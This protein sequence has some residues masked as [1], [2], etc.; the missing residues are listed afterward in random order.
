[1]STSGTIALTNGIRICAPAAPRRAGRVDGEDVL[2]MVEHVG[3]GS[4]D[5]AVHRAH[6]EADEIAVAELVGVVQ[7]A[8][9][10]RIDQQPGAAEL[11]RGGPCR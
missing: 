10:G 8:E 11:G 4:H 2:A 1:M 3:D 7:S 9:R 6:A 5:G